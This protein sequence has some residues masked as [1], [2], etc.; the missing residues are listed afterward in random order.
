[1]SYNYY[2]IYF[3]MNDIIII[4]QEI[5]IN[6]NTYDCSELLNKYLLSHTSDNTLVI[7]FPNGLYKFRTQLNLVSNIHILGNK[8]T[9]FDFSEYM[10]HVDITLYN[11]RHFYIQGSGK[12]IKKI[13]IESLD[14]LN[15]YDN[16]DYDLLEIYDPTIHWD[17]HFINPQGELHKKNECNNLFYKYNELNVNLIK[18]IK[19]IRI[20]DIHFIGISRPIASLIGFNI[21][22]GKNINI[23]N[24][25]L[26]KFDCIAINIRSSLETFIF[27]NEIFFE[28]KGQL[29]S[30]QYAINFQN[31]SRNG[32]VYKNKIYK[33]K[34]SLLTGHNVNH[35]GIQR[36]IYYIDNECYLTWHGAITNHN[37]CEKLTYMNNILYKCKYGMNNRVN[38]CILYNNKVF[39]SHSGFYLTKVCKNLKA[40][41]NL[42]DGCLFYVFVNEWNKPD[43]VNE[44]Y[45][46]V[47][48]K[49][50]INNCSYLYRIFDILETPQDNYIF[51]HDNQK[52]IKKNKPCINHKFKMLIIKNTE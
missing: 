21:I 14:E 27:N 30:T 36:D 45:N 47:F 10:Q 26:Y 15:D 2:F 40:H 20:S 23:C 33:G 4:C 39:D 12:V 17:T 51:I 50:N 7:Y 1:M 3:I 22:Y 19:N 9:Y 43:Y 6:E 5:G 38:N 16:L 37:A 11:Y 34:H 42:I 46:N 25:L 18:S 35:P 52:N 32:Y 44:R 13:K 41:K 29:N 31:S 24:N 8:K 48:Y 49:N 28:D